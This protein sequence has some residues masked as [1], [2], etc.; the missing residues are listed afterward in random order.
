MVYASEPTILP[1]VLVLLVTA[2][3]AV[4]LIGVIVAMIVNPKTRRWGIGLAVGLP[5]LLVLFPLFLWP[6][7]R[8]IA[9][10]PSSY[11]QRTTVNSVQSAATA[12]DSDVTGNYEEIIETIAEVEESR[13]SGKKPAANSGDPPPEKKA[14]DTSPDA[15]DKSAEPEKAKKS[16]DSNVLSEEQVSGLIRK[17]TRLVSSEL[18]NEAD[19]R[20]ALHT[21]WEILERTLAEQKKRGVK[22][23]HPGSEAATESLAAAPAAKPPKDPTHDRPAWLDSPQGR[24]P[25]GYGKTIVV[26]PFSTRDECNQA[27]PGALQAAVADYVERYLGR[28]AKWQVRLAND[29]IHDKM[30]RGEWEET[31]Q[32]GVGLMKQ[33]H[34][35][36]AFTSRTNELLK[37]KWH[38]AQVEQR[39]LYAGMGL[40][41]VLFVLLLAY[42]VLKVDLATKG[43]YRKH[44]AMGIA[45]PILS[46]LMYFLLAEVFFRVESP[47]SETTTVDRPVE[48]EKR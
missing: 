29:Y 35:R 31:K 10:A 22:E 26:G 1:G 38:E 32:T 17:M 24:T 40:A 13:T 8:S 20:S 14:P 2:A 39:V 4:L 3:L 6:G 15:P 43:A 27:L 41:G 34:V 12:N 11:I 33:L 46:I 7:V 16:A 30:I 9:P 44:M 48:V 19:R 28:E 18:P 36:L 25:Y 42:G 5:V 45:G 47:V 37:Q 21:F 23:K